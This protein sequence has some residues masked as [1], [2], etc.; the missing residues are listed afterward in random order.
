MQIHFVSDVTSPQ[1]EII[2]KTLKGGRPPFSVFT[3]VIIKTIAFE[4]N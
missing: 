3:K 2:F 1:K 4:I